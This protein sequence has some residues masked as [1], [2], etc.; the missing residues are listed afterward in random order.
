M[1]SNIADDIEEVMNKNLN[2][3]PFMK[4]YWEQ[5][6]FSQNKGSCVRYHHK[7]II[8]CLLIASKSASAYNK[9]T[10]IRYADLTKPQNIM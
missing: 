6:K 1:N 7:I 8:F 10:S 3:S 9:I 5:Q 2:V 4:L